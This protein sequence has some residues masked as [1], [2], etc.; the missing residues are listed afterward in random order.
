MAILP[1]VNIAIWQ[2]RH[3]TPGDGERRTVLEDPPIESGSRPIGAAMAF[4][5]KYQRPDFLSE[6]LTQAGYEKWL[7]RI[8]AAHVKRDRKRGNDTAIGEAYRLAIHSAVVHSGGFDHYTGERLH[9]S[10]VSTYSNDKSQAGG[11]TYKAGFALLPTVDHV[12]DGLG[13]ADFKICAWRTNDAKS[14]LTHDEFVALCRR[15]VK[16]FD[17]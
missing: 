16:H 7:R 17:R 13:E 3:L 2:N 12:G 5:R 14:D 1:N 6:D 8:A 4:I 15:V 10:L 11:R 9:W